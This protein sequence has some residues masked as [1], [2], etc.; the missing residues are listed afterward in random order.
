[1]C[2]NLLIHFHASSVALQEGRSRP[3]KRRKLDVISSA[4]IPDRAEAVYYHPD[5]VGVPSYTSIEAG[6]S[7]SS[8]SESSSSTALVPASGSSVPG[9]SNN[10]NAF[11]DHL[12]VANV[13]PELKKVGSDWFAVFN[14][15]AKRQL[16]VNLVYTWSHERYA[17]H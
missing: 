16:D 10:A 7:A 4:G 15:K 11:L 12:N 8:E 14:P 6:P 9:P 5:T 3:I 2:S 1:M 17:L 13:P